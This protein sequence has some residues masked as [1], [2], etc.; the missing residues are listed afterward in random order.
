MDLFNHPSIFVFVGLLVGVTF[1][2]FLRKRFVEGHRQ[3]IKDQAKQLIE[4]AIVEAEQLKKEAQLQSKEDA[5][6]VKQAAEEEL[7]ADRRELK[8][9]RQQLKK[10]RDAFGVIGP[11][12]I[13][14]IIRG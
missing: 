10:S 7:K 8:D 3:N 6:Q 4:T 14:P 5:Y 12:C 13:S 11:N 1:G 2:F 9:E